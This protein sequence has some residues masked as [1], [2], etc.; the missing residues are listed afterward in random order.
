[1][2]K[3]LFITVM[4]GIIFSKCSDSVSTIPTTALFNTDSIKTESFRVNI[5]KDTLLS[6][7]NGAWLKIEKGTF[8]SNSDSIT[9]EIKEAYTAAQII[10]AGLTTQTNGFPLSSGGMI[11]INAAAGQQVKI[12]KPFKVAVPA[13]FLEK[14]MQ[15]YK[16]DKQ[17]N[18]NI[19][20]TN[21]VNLDSNKQMNAAEK[22]AILFQ[23]KCASCH[24]IGKEGSGPDL[25]NIMK[26][27]NPYEG[28]NS[29][30]P[31]NH[32]FKKQYV[33]STTASETVN[34]K[35]VRADT[36]THYHSDP[37]SCN[38]INLFNNKEVDLS[39]DIEA[40]PTEWLDIYNYIENESDK[41]EFPYPRHAYLDSCIDSCNLYRDLKFDLERKKERAETKRNNLVNDNGP[42]VD[43]K[44]DP[45]WRQSN[46]IPPPGFS[47][48]VEPV[49]YPATYYQFTIET[50]G[51][52]NIDM[53]LDQKSGAEE[54]ELFV[55]V[56]GS[57]KEKIKIYL[58]IPSAK[59]LGEG[60]PSGKNENEYA[61]F[62]K[63]G[64]LPLPQN[65]KAY[66]LALTETQQ[67][68]AYGI[69][70]FTT[71]TTQRL[72]ISLQESTK[73]AFNKAIENIGADNLKITIQESKNAAAIKDA[74]KTIKQLEEELKKAEHLK[75]TR[76]DCDC[77]Q[78][79]PADVPK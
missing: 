54:S 11:Y 48:K 75:P 52:Y 78:P 28:E 6:T 50:F 12:Q 2:R 58:V 24:G 49:F 14:N 47:N 44:P 62:E 32:R 35:I 64:K 68:I 53:L 5:N 33:S 36:F 26:R 18:G 15:L 37:Y 29:Y 22:G 21:P 76:C 30:S 61:F 73:E 72:E 43:R 39:A 1:M 4:L 71:Q 7:I 74:D 41:K 9:L 69:K 8:S 19:N 79:F 67:S 40:N 59:V 20:W 45:T 56:T 25:A 63:R 42:L 46:S 66:I 31:L 55:T 57:Y 60:G 65:T 27:F 3:V 38:L 23:Q 17:S 77:G 13:D 70:E 51:W 34:G 16:G 10:K